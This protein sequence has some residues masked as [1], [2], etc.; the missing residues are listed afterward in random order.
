MQFV[1]CLC[2]CFLIFGILIADQVPQLPEAEPVIRAVDDGQS[3]QAVQHIDERHSLGRFGE[4]SE[5]QWKE[6][7]AHCILQLGES[8]DQ[9]VGMTDLF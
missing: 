2:H 6:L 9:L 4:S 3:F 7:A 1:E 8:V 5:D